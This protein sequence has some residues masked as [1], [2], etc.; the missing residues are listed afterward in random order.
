MATPDRNLHDR[1]KLRV[2]SIIDPDV[3]PDGEDKCNRH[4]REMQSIY[5]HVR[6]Q[7]QIYHTYGDK[8]LYYCPDCCNDALEMNDVDPDSVDHP[9]EISLVL[10]ARDAGP[11]KDVG[12]ETPLWEVCEN[13]DHPGVMLEV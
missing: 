13:D 12:T 2:V 6:H 10:A 8:R 5:P 1:D 7:G 11:E 4:A 9:A 3:E